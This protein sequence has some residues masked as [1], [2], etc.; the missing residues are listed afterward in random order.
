MKF[1]QKLHGLY[2]CDFKLV[3]VMGT[4]ALTLTL[5]LYPWGVLTLGSPYPWESLT[6][7]YPFLY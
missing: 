4:F 7:P 2:Q 6:L 5:T 1:Q 3:R